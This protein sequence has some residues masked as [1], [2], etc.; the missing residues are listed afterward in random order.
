MNKK[1]DEFIEK[2]IRTFLKEGSWGKIDNKQK[3]D[4]AKKILSDLNKLSDEIYDIFASDAVLDGVDSAKE[5]MRNIIAY[6]EK[7]LKK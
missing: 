3:L 4:K 5:E 7:E 6:A 1:L 2:K